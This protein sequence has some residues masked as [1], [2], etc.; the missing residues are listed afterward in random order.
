MW[1]IFTET[2]DQGVEVLFP[3]ATDR[4]LIDCLRNHAFLNRRVE[5]K[6]VKEGTQLLPPE[7]EQK[8]LAF[9]E[10]PLHLGPVHHEALVILGY[11]ANI[12][13]HSCNESSLFR[14]FFKTS[15]FFKS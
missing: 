10:L 1:K 9:L 7:R 11:Q 15:T 14:C 4:F 3:H 2:I 5:H 12:Y 6:A 13:Q 8:I